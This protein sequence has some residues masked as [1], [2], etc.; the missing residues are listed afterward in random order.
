MDKAPLNVLSENLAVEYFS[1]NRRNN[2]LRRAWA[3][4]QGLAEV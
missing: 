2:E 4:A 3:G 1:G